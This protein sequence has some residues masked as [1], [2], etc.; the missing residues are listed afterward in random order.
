MKIAR[1]C[2]IVFGAAYFLGGC[3][4]LPPAITYLGYVKTAVDVGVYAATEKTTTD[5]VLSAMVE[6]DCALFRILNDEQVCSEYET[7]DELDIYV[8]QRPN[9]PESELE[10]EVVMV[11]DEISYKDIQLSH[12]P[13]PSITIDDTVLDR[14]EMQERIKYNRNRI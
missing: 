1:L 10:V 12:K 5:H 8:V 6:K 7:H 14:L 2:F 13:H 4:G 11:P 3:A 9:E